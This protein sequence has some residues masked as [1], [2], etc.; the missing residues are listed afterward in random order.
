MWPEILELAYRYVSM[1]LFLHTHVIHL[2][3]YT[4]YMVYPGTVSATK[5]KL[6]RQVKC[7][8]P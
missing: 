7:D 3:W 8:N 2:I 1:F 4:L 6:K 5:N